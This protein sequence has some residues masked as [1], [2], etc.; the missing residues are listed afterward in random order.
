[1]ALQVGAHGVNGELRGLRRCRHEPGHGGGRTLIDVGGPHVEGRRAH[2][3][4]Q[5]DGQQQ[6]ARHEQT[7][8]LTVG[9]A[10][11]RGD[12]GE[13]DRSGGAVDEGGAEEEEGR[14]EGS[15]EEILERG[16]L[17]E[18]PAPPGQGTVSVSI[19]E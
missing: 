1:M 12:L 17:G 14:R 8:E 6:D 2:F 16:L 4:E 18:Q 13:V 15:E 7:L 5:A 9:R 10:D 19:L 3:E 11:A